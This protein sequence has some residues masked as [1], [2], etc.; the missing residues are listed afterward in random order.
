M[1]YQAEIDNFLTH[2]LFSCI[3][4]NSLCF[5]LCVL[6]STLVLCNRLHLFNFLYQD[7]TGYFYTKK[8]PT[9]KISMGDFGILIILQHA[10]LDYI[11]VTQQF[12]Y[13]GALDYAKQ[14]LLQCI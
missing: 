8:S 2:C 1:E 14:R 5:L 13:Y 12:F 10:V 9:E 7:F 6:S 3:M 11:V 4:F